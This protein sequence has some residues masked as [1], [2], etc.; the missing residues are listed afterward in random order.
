MNIS[1]PRIIT[2][3]AL[4]DNYI[5]LIVNGHEAI[6]VD[7]AEARPVLAAITEQQLRLAGILITHNHGDHL[8]GAAELH[9]KTGAKVYGPDDSRIPVPS[10]PLRDGERFECASLSISVM[11]LPGHTRTH[12]GYNLPAL[13]W[14]FTGDTLFCAGCGRL[15]ESTAAQMWHS[16]QRI[17]SLPD[18][19][20]IF[21]GHEYTEENLR[22][23]LSLEPDSREIAERLAQVNELR[24]KGLPSVP[25]TLALEKRTNPFL[26]V[27]TLAAKLGMAGASDAEVFAEIRRRKDRF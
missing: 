20:N 12:V 22:F 3:E 5:F 15:F 10:S 16:L 9:K 23:A 18:A 7:P 2:L 4:S 11:H 27:N 1:H 6:A 13:N 14:L 8:G 19:T 17:M 21:C 26:R 25:S 24:R